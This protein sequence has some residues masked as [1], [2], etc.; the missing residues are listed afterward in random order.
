MMTGIF[1]LILFC[2]LAGPAGL[3]L[4]V[5]SR[6]GFTRLCFAL[7]SSLC[8]FL[9]GTLFGTFFG[10]DMIREIIIFLMEPSNEIPGL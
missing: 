9:M 1:S 5:Y 8:A 3:C 2:S 10:A 6:Y 7:L 4:A